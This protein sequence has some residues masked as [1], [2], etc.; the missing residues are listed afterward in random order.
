MTTTLTTSTSKHAR[1]G[2]ADVHVPAATAT[3]LRALG[4][5]LVHHLMAAVLY[6]ESLDRLDQQAA[7]VDLGVKHCGYRRLFVRTPIVNLIENWR[8]PIYSRVQVVSAAC[9]AY[10]KLPA[11]ERRAWLTELNDF[12]DRV[13]EG[14]SK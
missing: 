14:S 11:Q 5:T 3:A 4:G 9:A 8:W 1:P 13:E 6:F 12:L 10:C 7:I 2:Y